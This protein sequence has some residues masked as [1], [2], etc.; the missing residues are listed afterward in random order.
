VLTERQDDALTVVFHSV[1]VVYLSQAVRERLRE[2]IEEVGKQGPLAW[3]SYESVEET[4]GF[5]VFV[6][7]LQ[8]WPGGERRR[9]AR[10][11]GHAN[12]LEWLP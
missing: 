4:P 10:L 11:D 1:S 3:L 12:T 6:L 8:R 5:Y 2:E 7:E 9:L